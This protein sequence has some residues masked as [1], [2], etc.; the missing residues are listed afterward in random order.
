MSE[1]RRQKPDVREQRSEVRER[2][3]ENRGQRKA[4]RS[5]ADMKNSRI[6]RKKKLKIELNDNPEPGTQNL[7]TQTDRIS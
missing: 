5:S 7:L 4:V 6:D 1:N 2:K 3:A